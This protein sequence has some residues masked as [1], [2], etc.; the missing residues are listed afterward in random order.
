[1]RVF[2][3]VTANNPPVIQEVND[4]KRRNPA[5]VKKGAGSYTPRV[6]ADSLRSTIQRVVS[7]HGKTLANATDE[8]LIKSAPKVSIA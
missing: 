3:R 2:P 7:F 6:Y 5:T 4:F 8:P 1:M